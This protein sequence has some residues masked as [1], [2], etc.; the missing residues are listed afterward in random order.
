MAYPTGIELGRSG[1]SL[2]HSSGSQPDGRWRIGE[3]LALAESDLDVNT[4]GVLVRRGKGGKRR[5][6]AW[7]AGAGS[8]WSRGSIT[9]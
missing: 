5:R 3:A 7:T 4:G 6:P 1:D 2:W 9:A 8:R